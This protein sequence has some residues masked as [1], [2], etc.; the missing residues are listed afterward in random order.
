[1]LKVEKYNGREK[2]VLS[3]VLLNLFFRL[4]NI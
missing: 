2:G 1:M 4:F 3:L